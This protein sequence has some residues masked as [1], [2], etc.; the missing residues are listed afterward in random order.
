MFSQQLF[1]IYCIGLICIFTSYSFA[2]SPEKI[3]S[4]GVYEGGVEGKPQ[5]VES[6]TVKEYGDKKVYEINTKSNLRWWTSLSEQK[7]VTDKNGDLFEYTNKTKKE[8]ISG[9]ESFEFL[10]DKVIITERYANGEVYNNEVEAPEG[11]LIVRGEG[12]TDAHPLNKYDHKMGGEQSIPV[13][14]VSH[15]LLVHY[16]T[17]YKGKETIQL[18][19]QVWVTADHFSVK[20]PELDPENDKVTDY[21]I[22]ERGY[23]VLFTERS[24]EASWIYFQESY[25]NQVDEGQIRMIK[26][27]EY[28]ATTR[29]FVSK[30]QEGVSTLK[31]NSEGF[32]AI[33]GYFSMSCDFKWDDEHQPLSYLECWM[34]PSREETETVTFSS[35]SAHVITQNSDGKNKELWLDLKKGM[36]FRTNNLLFLEHQRI[37]N[38][39]FK[40]GGIQADKIMESDGYVENVQGMREYIGE[41][42]ITV[43][44]KKVGAKKF[45]YT[46]KD[47]PNYY[48]LEWF[49]NNLTLLRG[50]VFWPATGR[51][52][53]E[54]TKL[55]GQPF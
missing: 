39:D 7:I 10:R 49:D 15:Q 47:R 22:D 44:G 31:L 1:K 13:V 53:Y 20:I 19:D 18:P 35:G 9:T 5:M 38:Y 34:T 14:N 33:S 43:A 41:E 37:R 51:L 17:A 30:T 50:E 27:G 23:L 16:V 54:L 24:K 32:E 28:F 45:K 36:A 42:S 40:V 25:N 11:Y 46:R 2:Q 4:S 3:I 55:E 26:N 6:W 12:F 29:W 52:A 48:L 21:W 8:A